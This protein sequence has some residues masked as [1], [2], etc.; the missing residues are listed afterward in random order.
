MAYQVIVLHIDKA[1]V[2]SMNIEPPLRAL[3]VLAV[4]AD[5][6]RAHRHSVQLAFDGYDKDPR[7]VYEHEAVRRFVQ[8]LTQEFPYWTHFA[9]LDDDETLA[10]IMHCLAAPV[11]VN[12]VGK[13]GSLSVLIDT[14]AWHAR[15]MDLFGHMNALYRDMGITDADRSETTEAIAAWA[16]R[17]GL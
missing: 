11:E 8:G 14:A 2:E 5:V 16:K 13:R 6:V 10:V 12:R 15:L 17:V 9:S 4:T 3:R 7:A 1:S